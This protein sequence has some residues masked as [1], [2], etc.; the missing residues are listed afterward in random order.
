MADH[1]VDPF[2]PN[3]LDP[4][5]RDLVLELRA[6]GFATTDSGDG[7]SKS[8]S[9]RVLDVPHVAIQVKPSKIASEAR[10]LRG[11]VEPLFDE[12]MV[13]ANRG[14]GWSILASY[15]PF[16]DVAILMLVR[17]PSEEV[18][19]AWEAAAKEPPHARWMD[20]YPITSDEARELIA[21][22]PTCSECPRPRVAPHDHHWMEGSLHP[23]ATEGVM[24]FR[25]QHPQADVTD[26]LLLGH[27]ECKHCPAVKEWTD[28][29]EVIH[30]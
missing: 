17:E 4:G 15:D 30:G 16:T 23:H 26:E 25:Q 1:N 19:S 3:L 7:F 8:K 18:M 13:E 24:E 2:D 6:R 20:G 22:C 10:R 5:I 27:L 9:Q 28:D 29:V 14:G 12:P 21:T 11:V